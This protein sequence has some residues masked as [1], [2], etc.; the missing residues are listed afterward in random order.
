LRRWLARR[1]D[2]SSKEITLIGSGRQGFCLS[3]GKRIGRPFGEHS[4]L[5]FAVIS[6]RLF[7]KLVAVFERW[8]AEYKSGIVLPRNERERLLWD[9]NRK[10]IATGLDRGFID[11]HKLPTWNRYP[12]A[13]MIGQTRYVANEKLRITP[14][15]PAVHNLSIRVYRD[16]DSFIRQMAINLEHIAVDQLNAEPA[17]QMPIRIAILGWG[18]LLWDHNADFDARHDEWLF[19]GPVLGLEFSRVSDSRNGALTLVIDAPNG[20]LCRVA[21]TFSKRKDP[22]DAICDLMS[23]EGTVRKK[24]GFYSLDGYRQ[25]SRDLGAFDS[26]SAWAKSKRIDL[27]IWTDLE[28]NFKQKSRLD[29]EFS[30]ENA[31]S[32]L[33]ALDAEGKAKAIEYL[34]RAPA[35]VNTPLRNAVQKQPW[36]G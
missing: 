27:V 10:S 30:V 11:P 29:Q 1:L 2:V 26:I 9:A 18:S 15:A 13:Q 21:Y 34:K 32:H 25:Q 7:G 3:P 33:A 6:S 17:P 31:I 16:W 22:E 14:V 5:D 36:F 8:N 28:S 19:D 12:E 24:M 23:R 20:A 4:D 35:F